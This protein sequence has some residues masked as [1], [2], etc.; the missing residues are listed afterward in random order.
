MERALILASPPAF[1]MTNTFAVCCGTLKILENAALPGSHLGMARIAQ[2][3]QLFLQ[4]LQRLYLERSL[5]KVPVEH[6]IDLVAGKVWPT[7]EML[8]CPDIFQRHA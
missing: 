7:L 4:A 3:L 5:L 1:A 6:G 2:G 8:Q